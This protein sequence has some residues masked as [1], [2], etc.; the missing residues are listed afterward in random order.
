MELKGKALFNL[1]RMSWLEDCNCEI[2]EWQVEDLRDLG[3]E[4]LFSRLKE[5]GLILDEKGFYLYAENCNDP[6][7][8]T[9]CVWFEEEDLEGHDKAY[10]ILF[11]LWRRLLP[12]NLC[13][14]VFCDEMDQLIELYD[15]G[16]LED[17]EPL[18]NALLILEDI[19]D[20]AYDK[21]GNS[22]LIFT[23]VAN[24]CAH[25][26][27][28]F[29]FDYIA[30]QI[31]EKNE[32]YASELIDGFYDYFTDR[33]RFDLLRARLF[34]S[35]DVEESHIIYSRLLEELVEE[36]DLELILLVIE[37]LIHHGDVRLFM[38]AV[39]L[40]LPLLKREDEFQ[41]LL[42]MVSEY[43]RCLDWDA[44]ESVVQGILSQRCSSPPE[45]P[46]DP[47][48]QALAHISQ[49]ISIH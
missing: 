14:S 37:S 46:L 32:T 47:A 28:R 38:Q 15:Q 40:A 21:K 20:E 33:K 5:L 1:L 27:E 36:P 23:E 17:E 8:L 24:F 16:E 3:I 6:E 35:S 34:A 9:D 45:K 42:T 25:D 22:Q 2:K 49:M 31:L 39:R 10:L 30:D 19:L 48:D 7:E 4:E 11:E 26:L 13:L 41:N 12:E 43:Y 18:Q 44:E 29:I